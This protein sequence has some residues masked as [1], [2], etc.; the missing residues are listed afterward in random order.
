[1]LKCNKINP[2]VIEIFRDCFVC[3]SNIIWTIFRSWN[4][5]CHWWVN[6]TNINTLLFIE[7]RGY[8]N[9]HRVRPMSTGRNSWLPTDLVLPSISSYLTD[10]R[11]HVSVG[12]SRSSLLLSSSSRLSEYGVPNPNQK[13]NQRNP[14]LNPGLEFRVRLTIW[15]TFCS[16]V[17]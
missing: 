5:K 13:P 2:K 6:L 10:R 9:I 15:Q 11:Q 8:K 4:G 1:M 3:W 14:N 17:V 7:R 16:A 12:S